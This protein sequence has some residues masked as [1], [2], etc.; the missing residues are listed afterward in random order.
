MS[1][2]ASHWMRRLVALRRITAAQQLGWQSRLEQALRLG[3][4]ALGASSGSICSLV[5]R[6]G[7]LRV[8]AAWPPGTLEPGRRLE[9]HRT[10]MHFQVEDTAQVSVSAGNVPELADPYADGITSDRESIS[11]PL[12]AA[13]GPVGVVSFR[14]LDRQ[15][16]TEA[17]EAF[18]E[19]LAAWLAESI[20][21]RTAR[22]DLRDARARI[23]TT[24]AIDPETGLPNRILGLDYLDREVRRAG[25]TNEPL[26]V[27]LLQVPQ[28]RFLVGGDEPELAARAL[29]AVG[30]AL[31]RV[32]RELDVAVRYSRGEFLL[33]WPGTDPVQAE[34]AAQRQTAAIAGLD[35][36]DGA[37]LRGFVG[38][39]SWLAPEETDDLV[40]RADAE[41][42]EAVAS[43]ARI[44]ALT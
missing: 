4:A 17:D 25:R 7:A 5:G 14:R 9:A 20:A 8:E 41:L 18:L 26:S 37:V 13:A 1:S 30:S 39:A 27:C 23:E 29:K 24:G 16:W 34:L 33:V 42:R 44:S 19:V 3:A 2:T 21:V 15:P 28:L 36:G 43:G 6:D 12:K 10:A 22:R 40:D 38:L 11:A 32:K 31:D 35:L